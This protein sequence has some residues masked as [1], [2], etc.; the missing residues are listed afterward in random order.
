VDNE[1]LTRRDFVSVVGSLGGLW[2]LGD[3]LER[4][5]ALN[6]ARHQVSSKQPKLLFFSEEQAADVDAMA[7]RIIPTDDTPGAHE[8]GVVYFIDKSLTTFGKEQAPV[9]AEGLKKLAN[10]VQAT[11]PSE[12]RFSALIPAQQDEVLK[13]IEQTPFFGLM[14][15]ATILGM[16]A[17]PSYGGNRNFIGWKLIGHDMALDFNPPFGWYDA[18]ANLKAQLG[19]AGGGANQP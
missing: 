3:S 12:T 5:D 17:L 13:S 6:H 2:I 9:F 8:A 14:R 7:S 4:L 16:F 15:V 18:P 10:D 11:F 19:A 1:F